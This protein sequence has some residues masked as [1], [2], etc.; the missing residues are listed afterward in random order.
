M[1][2]II[3]QILDYAINGGE[4]SI[5]KLNKKFSLAHEQAGKIID[6]LERQNILS[7]YTESEKRTANINSLKTYLWDKFYEHKEIEEYELA[8]EYLNLLKKL[9]DGEA[10][11]WLGYFYAK[12]KGVEKSI[13]TAFELFDLAIKKGCEIPYLYLGNIYYFGDGV[14]IDYKKAFEYYSRAANKNMPYAEYSIGC[15]YF[16][17]NGVEKDEKKALEYFERAYA[18]GEEKAKKYIDML[19][20]IEKL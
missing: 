19:K 3:L 8:I 20:D 7:S 14:K 16:F 5:A 12:G 15:I 4:I 10:Y 11:S 6:E 18:L 9:D 2:K 17:G 1:E 13:E